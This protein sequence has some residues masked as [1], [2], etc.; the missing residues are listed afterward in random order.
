M[1]IGLTM[2]VY[3]RSLAVSGINVEDLL[4]AELKKEICNNLAANR[5]GRPKVKT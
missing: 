3:D 1:K 5:A 4:G 2:N